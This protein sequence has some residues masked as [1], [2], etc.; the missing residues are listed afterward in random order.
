MA[1][2]P[3]LFLYARNLDEAVTPRDLMMPLAISLG[4]TAVFLLVGWIVFR[5]PKAVGLVATGWLLLFFSYGR[6]SDA[7]E[8]HWFGQD[9]YLLTAWGMLA[10]LV[11]AAAYVFRARLR[12]VTSALNLIAAGLVI[13]NILPI[14]LYRPPVSN[15]RALSGEL[16]GE[17][18]KAETSTPSMPDIYYIVPEDYGDDRTNREMF[19]VDTRGLTRYLE[20]QGFYVAK[21]SMTNYPVTHQD[22]AA[23]MYFQY[24]PALLGPAATNN[25]AVKRALQGPAV[26]QFLKEL[27]YRYVHM[28]FWWAPTATDPTADVEVRPGSLSEFSSVLEDTTILPALSRN[29]HVEQPALDPKLATYYQLRNQFVDL[30]RIAK[31]HGPKFVFA[32]LGLPHPPCVFDRDGGYSGDRK[33]SDAKKCADQVAFTAQKLKEVIGQLLDATHGR[34]V[35]IVQ[36]DEGPYQLDHLRWGLIAHGNYDRPGAREELLPKYRILN[37]YFLPGV[38]HTRLY[39]TITPV[40]SFRLVFDLYFHT[41]LRLLPDQMWGLQTHPVSQFVNLTELLTGGNGCRGSGSASPPVEDR[42]P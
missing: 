31:L 5:S 33:E 27:G 24:L 25:D 23:A 17:L 26:S 3:I 39:P 4:V 30:I 19:G 16:A 13:M 18:P 41:K 20:A 8:P 34:A 9:V 38:A 1:A 21:N 40:N 11:L 15:G 29:F 7:L 42:C 10:A 6:V 12:A 14:V 28:G 2:F 35:I 22:L 32:H 36:T 37:A